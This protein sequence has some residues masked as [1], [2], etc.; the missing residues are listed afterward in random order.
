M[1]PGREKGNVFLKNFL[2]TY[3]ERERG[4]FVVLL[5]HSLVASYMCPEQGP[6]WQQWRIE[7]TLL[8]LSYLEGQCFPIG[9]G[10][11]KS[12]VEDLS[13]QTKE[14]GLRAGAKEYFK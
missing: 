5:M 4:P 1:I 2:F 9:G 11:S 7:T 3:C 13:F 10:M 12:Q 8:S 14:L 6:N